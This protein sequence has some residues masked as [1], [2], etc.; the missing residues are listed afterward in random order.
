MTHTKPTPCPQASMWRSMDT[1]PKDGTL[2]LAYYKADAGIYHVLWNDEDHDGWISHDW[3][4]TNFEQTDFTHWM[5]APPSPES[6][7]IALSIYRAMLEIPRDQPNLDIKAQALEI[8]ERFTPKLKRHVLN[9][10]PPV[11]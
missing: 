4:I 6:G 8:L 1:A 5:P 11:P 2:I 7:E 3:E 10:C 9:F